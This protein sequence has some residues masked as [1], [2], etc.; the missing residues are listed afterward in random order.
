MKARIYISTLYQEFRITC[1]EVSRMEICDNSPM[2]AE[3][4]YEN[5]QSVKCFS[6]EEFLILENLRDSKDVN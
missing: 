3:E 1:L 4:S 2:A 5:F 6:R